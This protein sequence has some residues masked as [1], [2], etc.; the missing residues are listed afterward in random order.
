MNLQSGKR[1]DRF[2]LVCV[3]FSA[4]P[5]HLCHLPF[6]CTLSIRT[7]LAMSVPLTFPK[8]T[9][10]V[11]HEDFLPSVSLLSLCIGPF[12]ICTGCILRERGS[13]RTSIR[14]AERETGGNELCLS[15]TGKAFIKGRR[16]G[17]TRD[18]Y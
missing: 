3:F 8:M 10:K 6:L 12:L 15:G 7:P 4:S 16:T 1:M 11:T 5:K 2:W 14:K 13:F 17:Q 18:C 9:V